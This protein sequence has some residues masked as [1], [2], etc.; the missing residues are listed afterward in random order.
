MSHFKF[1]LQLMKTGIVEQEVVYIR[2]NDSR[3]CRI[4]YQWSFRGTLVIAN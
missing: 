3:V 2:Q 1:R 4:V